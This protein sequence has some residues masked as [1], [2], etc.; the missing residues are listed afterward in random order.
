MSAPADRTGP[1]ATP[2]ADTTADTHLDALESESI[3]II[4]EAHAMLDR[5]AL[6]WSLDADATVMLWLCRKAFFGHVPFPVVHVD[7]GRAFAETYAFR[8][9]QA[10]AWDLRLVPAPCPPDSASDPSLPPAARSA[11]RVAAGLEAVIAREGFTGLL[12]GN[13]RDEEGTGA[14]ERVFS[15]RGGD[16]AQ[17]YRYQP[18]EFWDHYNGTVPAG[19][20]VR[21]HPLL[22]WSE[23]DVWRYTAREGIPVVPLYFAQDRRRH[24]SVGDQDVAQSVESDAA[25]VEEIVAELEMTGRAAGAGRD[26]DREAGDPVGRLLGA[27]S[28][29]EPTEEREALPFR[30][31]VQGVYAFDERRIVAGRIESGRVSAGDRV[32]FSP[33]NRTARVVSIETWNAPAPLA[34]ATAGRSV[35]LTL[36][37][38]LPVERGET[39]SHEA[40]PPIE[41]DVFRARLFWL[42]RTPLRPGRRCTLQL[43]TAAHPVE[44]QSIDRVIDPSGPDGP[45]EGE[46]QAEIGHGRIA[47]AVLRSGA[48][49]ALDEHTA[50]PRTGR[51]VLVDGNGIA[52]GGLVSME[53]YPD[54]RSLI[55]GR[56]SN[57]SIIDHGVSRGARARRNRHAGGVIWLT[58]L[59]GAGKSTLAI[60]AEEHLFRKGYQ[61]YALD[62][63]NVRHGLNATLGF[64]PEDRA[65]NIRRVG[66]VAALF[67]DAGFIVVTAFIS[68]Y[69]SD[70]AR[71]RAAA[72]RSSPKG[73]H[74]VY[75]RAPLA[76]CEQRDPRG[77]YRRARA[78]EIADFTGVS[79]PYEAPE[80][81]ELTVD[82]GDRP[83]EQ[84][85]RALVDYVER[86]FTL[87]ELREESTEDPGAPG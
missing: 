72:E 5:P 63:D 45:Q 51:F 21:V 15:P 27:L 73:F 30:M 81:P 40:R 55:T 10:A 12:A 1:A 76:V 34:H 75:V 46:A 78:G 13:R 14:N 68:P 22:R 44:V 62:G 57:V 53:G 20:H 67:A 64:S 47:E 11:A 9:H 85:L 49:L 7:T 38:R 60:A 66:E 35:G 74:E 16:G 28:A 31:S 43:C 19:G 86:H 41:T 71:A 69:R 18:P 8:D 17:A 83:V 37:Q 54:Q 58:G 2:V 48:M 70:R 39:V 50:N 61:V 26:A 87:A 79:A 65:E 82:T 32:L 4:R 3:H 25:T 42:G 84:S 56:A 23:I 80:V 52:G 36:D 33:S 24:R 77:L 6:L 29:S 59:S